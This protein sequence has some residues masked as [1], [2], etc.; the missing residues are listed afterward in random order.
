VLVDRVLYLD[1][2]WSRQF[3]RDG[4]VWKITREHVLD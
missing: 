2:E 3:L 1:M 4:K